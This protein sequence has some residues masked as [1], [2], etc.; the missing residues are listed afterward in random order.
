M[1][2][3]TAELPKNALSKVQYFQA[4]EAFN[5]NETEIIGKW[6]VSVPPEWALH[7]DGLWYGGTKSEG[8]WT[9]WFDTKDKAE[10]A[11]KNATRGIIA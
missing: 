9:G 7:T 8:G 1:P 4:V 3:R 6:C 2:K 10:E 11:F 5:P